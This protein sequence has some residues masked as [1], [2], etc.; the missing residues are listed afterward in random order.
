MMTYILI[1]SYLV[2]IV[3]ANNIVTYMGARGLIFT[4]F[5]LIPFDLIARDQLQDLWRSKNL[6]I[7]MACLIL[8]GSL[9]AYIT[10]PE[11]ANISKASAISFLFA[12][13]IDYVFYT[14]LDGKRKFIKMN[15][16]NIASSICD[17]TLF[18]WIAFGSISLNI[19]AAQTAFKLL[20]GLLWSIIF[21][22]YLDRRCAL[23]K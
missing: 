6:F 14:L 20:G 5:F 13:S 21:I 17:S 4:A 7:K 23:R 3:A 2:A 16:S 19:A 15:L 18:Q 10:N 12:G 11:T 8:S 9:I 22:R 1:A